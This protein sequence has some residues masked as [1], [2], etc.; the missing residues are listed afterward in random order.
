MRILLPTPDYPPM[1][2]G[3]QRLLER[4]VR[5]SRFSYAVVTLSAPAGSRGPA[6]PRVT[7]TPRL[8][9]QRPSVGMLNAMTI[10]R[11]IRWR[12]DAVLSGHVVTGP[13]ALTVQALLGAPAIQYLYGKEL[14]GRPGLTRHVIQHARA[15]VAIS[16]HTRR[17]ALALGAP[18][19]RLHLILP[20]V[21]PPVAPSPWPAQRD[22]GAPPTIL[23]VAR[24]RDRYKGFDVMIK[25]LPL[26][27]AR[28]PNA[29]WVLVGDGPL[30]GEL[31]AMAGSQGVADHVT[32]AG[33]LNDEERDGWL[34][35]ADVFAMPSR[36]LPDG[37]GGEGFGIVYLEAG[38]HGLPCVAGNVGGSVD[39]VIDGE[40]GLLVDPTDHVAV[41]DAIVELLLDPELRERLGEAGRARAERLSW[42]HMAGEVD[43]LIEQV[44]AAGKR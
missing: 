9:G 20:G 14:E 25:A 39:A 29:H 38:A 40:T 10:A 41:A 11:A 12:P 1:T 22:A 18:T 3:I 4:L 16:S 44:V 2:G 36:L 21:D 33:A 35:R 32:F 5:H 30:R 19:D 24:L 28:V 17:Q 26:I 23:T 31:Q 7:R 8:G 43:A 37:R 13:A 27:R 6:T 15:S 34:D 42:A